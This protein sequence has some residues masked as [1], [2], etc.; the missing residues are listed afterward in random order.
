MDKPTK[1]TSNFAGPAIGP[2]TRKMLKD[3]IMDLRQQAPNKDNP[4]SPREGEETSKR[5]AMTSNPNEQRMRDTWENMKKQ[6][7]TATTT[8]ASTIPNANPTEKVNPGTS[9]ESSQTKPSK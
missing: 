7:E 6:H 5:L 4:Q 1:E 8:T 9:S 3:L 2:R